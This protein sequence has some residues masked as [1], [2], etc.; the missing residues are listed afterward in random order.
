MTVTQTE[1]GAAVVQHSAS[2]VSEIQHADYAGDRAALAQLHDRLPSSATDPRVAARLIYWRGFALW[3]RAINGFN[4]GSAR[5]E[6]RSDLE[7]GLAE[8]ND[9]AAKDPNFVDAKIGALGCISL[10][11]YL[12]LEDGAQMDDPRVKE[13]FGKIRELRQQAMALSPDNPR[14]L[15]VLG[16]NIWKSPPERGGGE[17]NALALYERGLAAARHASRPADPLEPTWGDPSC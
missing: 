2:L 8:F 10:M 15:W 4:D 11:G 5:P 3:R 13:L 12:L 17:A 1:T 9:S 7:R 6:L 16:P 14:L